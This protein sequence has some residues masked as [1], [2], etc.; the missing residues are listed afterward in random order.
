M[1]PSPFSIDVVTR[2]LG[3]RVASVE[4]V[5][6]FAASGAEVARLQVEGP[7]GRSRTVIGKSATGT[8]LAA[9]RCE[10]RFY[11]QLAPRWAHPA[12]ALLG[13]LEDGAGDGARLVLLTEDLEAAGYAR[14]L[15]T[16][17]PEAQ[18]DAL[19][20]TLVRLHAAFW[21]H[22]GADVVDWAHPAPSVTQAAQAWPVDVIAANAAAVRAE[23]ARFAAAP[24]LTAAERAL[25]P[26]LLDAWECQFRARVACGGLTLIHADFHVLGNIFVAPGRPPRVIDWSELKP[27]LGPHDVAYLLTPLPAA[28]RRARDAAVLRRYWDGLRAAGIDYPWTLCEWDYRFSQFAKLFQSVF[29]GSVRWFRTSAALLDELDGR[30][31]LRDPPPA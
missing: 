7:D 1:A 24:E 23:A 19:I 27:G 12:P 25:V 29:Q 5:E 30:A 16:G 11:E 2:A 3:E 17:V 10:R 14:P 22:L 31:A 9:A 18:V 4:V 20:D 26:E 15:A 28:D 21:D 6:R 13:A 8:G